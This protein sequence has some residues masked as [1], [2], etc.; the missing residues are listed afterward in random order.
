MPSEDSLWPADWLHVAEKDL[1]R[2]HRMLADGDAEAAGFY[3][4]QALEKLLKG[5]LLLKGWELER[6]HDLESLLNDALAYDTSLESFRAACQKITAFYFV[7]RYPS[8]PS[9]GLTEED[10]RQSLEQ[11]KELIEKLR[12][13]IAG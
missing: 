13:A 7:D 10:V 5:F 3:L 12:R 11:T 4:Q 9:A 6:I 2:L 8:I 1:D